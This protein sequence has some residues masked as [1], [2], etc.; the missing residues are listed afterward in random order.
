MTYLHEARLLG[1]ECR[2]PLQRVVQREHVGGAHPRRFVGRVHRLPEGNCPRAAPRL[3]RPRARV[4]VEDLPHEPRGHCYGVA[5][6][7][8]LHRRPGKA[9]RESQGDL[10]HERGGH[11]CVP[12]GPATHGARGPSA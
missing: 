4:P 10:M 11:E 3:P 7:L 8:P 6:A 1:V 5:A 12:G 2:E 9:A